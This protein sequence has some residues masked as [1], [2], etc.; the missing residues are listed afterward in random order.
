MK[1]ASKPSLGHVSKGSLKEYFLK[2][3]NS[4]F[5][6]DAP[7]LIEEKLKTLFSNFIS[8]LSGTLDSFPGTLLESCVLKLSCTINSS[9][10]EFITAEV[11]PALYDK[12]VKHLSECPLPPNSNEQL[13][14]FFNDKLD[15]L[16]DIIIGLSSENSSD[17]SDMKNSVRNLEAK[18]FSNMSAMRDQLAESATKE[19]E[20]SDQIKRRLNDF[21]SSINAMSHTLDFLVNSL[22]K[23]DSPQVVY[24]NPLMHNWHPHT[25]SQ[26]S[27]NPT[28]KDTLQ[29]SAPLCGNRAPPPPPPSPFLLF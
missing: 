28:A 5:C 26:R 25:H 16:Q 2:N 4:D 24:N 15:S 13:Q 10:Q 9:V 1:S 8:E 18:I 11:I 21:H 27:S 7:L 3:I 6:H 23:V 29:H 12:V 19:E 17:L 20:R 22:H 14:D